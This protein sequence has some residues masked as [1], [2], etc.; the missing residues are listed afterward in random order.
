M[1]ETIEFNRASPIFW[2]FTRNGYLLRKTKEKLTKAHI[3]ESFLENKSD[4]CAIWI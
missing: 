3:L 2:Y 4:I 1:P